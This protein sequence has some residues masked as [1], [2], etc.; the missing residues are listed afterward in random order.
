MSAN[1]AESIFDLAVSLN[2]MNR[3]ALLQQAGW[4]EQS[5]RFHEALIDCIQSGDEYC[6]DQIARLLVRSRKQDGA[7]A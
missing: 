4:S 7:V 1:L 6:A 3:E 2:R 5:R